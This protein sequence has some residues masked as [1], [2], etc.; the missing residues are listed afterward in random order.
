M[1]VAEKIEKKI[2]RIEE[3]LTFKY[4]QLGISKE[5]YSAATK[6]TERLI[7]KGLI[8]RVSKGVFYKPK[9]SRFGELKPREEELLRPYLFEGNKRVGY[10]TGNS[11]Y[12]RMGLT[13]QVSNTIKIASR[14]KRISTKLGKVEVKP[15]KSYVDINDKNYYFLEIL[16]ALKDFKIIPD[17]DKKSGVKLMQNKIQRLGPKEKKR[18]I[19]YALEYPPRVRAFLGAIMSVNS[20]REDILPLKESLNPLTS[21][22]LGINDNVLPTASQWCIE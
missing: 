9:K 6:A 12:N 13:T 8:K 22:T 5:E 16:D 2:G 3:G 11:L 20:K 7:R 17:L 4:E 1:N 14:S 10:I 21:Y 18:L 15:L 19:K